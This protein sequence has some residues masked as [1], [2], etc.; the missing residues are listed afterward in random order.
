VNGCE[1]Q[2]GTNADCAACGNACSAPIG[3]TACIGGA[4]KVTACPTHRADCDGMAG[5]G[6]E[7]DLKTTATCGSCTTQCPEAFICA[8]G[9]DPNQYVCACGVD[10]ACLNGGICYLGA[11]CV[12]GGTACALGQRCTLIGT[13]F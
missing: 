4:C 6:C 13:C 7:T 3:T 11:V 10:A 1:T 5:N 9:G 12:C 8:Q 2:L